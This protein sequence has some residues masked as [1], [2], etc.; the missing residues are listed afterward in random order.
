MYEASQL[1]IDGEDILDETREFSS[2]TLKKWQTAEVDH[3]S[4]RVIRNTLDQP[5]HKSLS[6]FTARNLLTDFKGTNGWTNVFQELAKMDFII[7]Q[8]L[9]QEEIVL[10]S[11]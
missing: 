1:G 2:Q 8:S 9:H 3:F 7:V 5:Y 10:I 11:K 6:R 4:G